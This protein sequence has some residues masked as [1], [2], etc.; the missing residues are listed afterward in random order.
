MNPCILPSK[1]NTKTIWGSIWRWLPRCQP[2]GQSLLSVLK[3]K[4]FLLTL[5]L[6]SQA[7][8]ISSNSASDPLLKL[9]YFWFL[10]LPTGTLLNQTI[11]S[12]VAL[13]WCFQIYSSP[14]VCSEG[15][16]QPILIQAMI[17]K[18][19]ASISVSQ[20]YEKDW[21][22]PND[23]SQSH[24]FLRFKNR[25]ALPGHLVLSSSFYTEQNIY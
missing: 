3:I 20:F 9:Q 22:Y 1:E 16:L 8:I 17:W 2:V 12:S 10:S 6:C 4:S 14:I 18:Y 11:Y 15:P 25:K 24:E 23:S 7:Q 5:W 21:N 13:G 19:F